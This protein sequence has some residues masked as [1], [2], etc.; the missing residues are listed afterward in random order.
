MAKV[1]QLNGSFEGPPG[2]DGKDGKSAYEYA[3][4]GGYTGTEEE[5]AEKLATNLQLDATLRDDT[6]AAPA[7]MVGKLKGDLAKKEPLHKVLSATLVAGET[8]LTFT[9]TAITDNAMI[10]I[11]TNEWGVQPS[12]VEQSGNTLTLTFDAHS[13]DIGV[14]VEVR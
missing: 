9:D 3:Q 4:D 6:K 14:K 2:A 11:Y 8:T 12:T 5:F 10:Y 7:G 13:A 1:M